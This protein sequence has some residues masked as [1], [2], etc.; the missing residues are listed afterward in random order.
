MFLLPPS[1]SLLQTLR[2]TFLP[3]TLPRSERRL[4]VHRRC[5]HALTA[6]RSG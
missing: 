6:P 2:D 1:T 5:L 3:C 4:C